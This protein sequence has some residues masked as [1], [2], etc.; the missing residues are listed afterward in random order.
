MRDQRRHRGARRPW[1]MLV[2]RDVSFGNRRYFRELLQGSEEGIA[3]NILS[4]RLKR[5][6]AAGLLARQEAT[7]GH[8]A[9]YSLTEAGIQTLPVMA[10][11]GN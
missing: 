11:M 5:L 7:R 10:A 9:A 8:R 4:S 3:S 1:S 2:L 6:V